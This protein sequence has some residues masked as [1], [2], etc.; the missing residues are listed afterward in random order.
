MEVNVNTCEIISYEIQKYSML[1]RIKAASKEENPVLDYEI[2]ITE[3][4][5]HSMGVNTDDLKITK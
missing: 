2:R 1:Q 5:L 3:I 4:T